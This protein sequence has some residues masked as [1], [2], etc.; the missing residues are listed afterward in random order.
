M[1]TT[2]EECRAYCT[3]LDANKNIYIVTLFISI[4]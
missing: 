4:Y 2:Y 3:I 1:A